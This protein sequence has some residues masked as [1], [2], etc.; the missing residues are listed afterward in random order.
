MREDSARLLALSKLRPEKDCPAPRDGEPLS[1]TED[2][3]YL[4]WLLARGTRILL[5]YSREGGPLY[6][7]EE[8]PVPPGATLRQR[9]A[10]KTVRRRFRD[11]FFRFR[12][13]LSDAGP[14]CMSFSLGGKILRKAGGKGTAAFRSWAS[15]LRHPF[16]LKEDPLTK[17][18]HDLP[19]FQPDPEAPPDDSRLLCPIDSWVIPVIGTASSP[20]WTWRNLCGREWEHT[21]CPHCLG[22]F[23]QRLGR[24]N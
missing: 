24:M 16:S 6:L 3:L 4:A 8:T 15:G 18:L 11:H 20:S 23:L 21:L 10:A 7:A 1:K 5:Q 14:A 19:L 9:I 12:L 13:G 2:M 17:G 22:S